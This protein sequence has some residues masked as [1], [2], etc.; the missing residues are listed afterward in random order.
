[1][2]AGL[3]LAG[4]RV[5]IEAEDDDRLKD[6]I[7]IALAATRS[8]SFESG[9]RSVA[10]RWRRTQVSGQPHRRRMGAGTDPAVL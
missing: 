6:V 4:D 5:V 3:G 1:M 10:W 8:Q 9:G 2:A 7:G